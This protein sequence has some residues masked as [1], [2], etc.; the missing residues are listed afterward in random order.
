MGPIFMIL[1]V[2]LT[3]Y[4]VLA[5]IGAR[6]WKSRW[7]RRR[8]HG[9]VWQLANLMIRLGG[10]TLDSGGLTVVGVQ[11]DAGRRPEQTSASHSRCRT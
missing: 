3:L 6:R 5:K 9:H 11:P 1:M 8:L 7:R 2:Q 4:V 10:V